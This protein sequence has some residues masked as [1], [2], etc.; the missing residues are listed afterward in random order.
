MD[1]III[2]QNNFKGNIKFIYYDRMV[3]IMKPSKSWVVKKLGHSK[4]I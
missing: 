1:V 3:C 4:N 2:Q